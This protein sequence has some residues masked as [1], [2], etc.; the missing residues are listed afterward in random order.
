MLL[1]KS[2]PV[3]MSISLSDC[4]GMPFFVGFFVLLVFFVFLVA[5][6]VCLVFFVLLFTF[7]VHSERIFDLRYWLSI[8]FG[9]FVSNVCFFLGPALEGYGH[10]FG[11]WSPRLSKVM[12]YVGLI[13][14]ALVAIL[15]VITYK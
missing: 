12:F 4:L 11:V 15:C 8:L 14:T 10:F 9:A 2:L 7:R 13:F 6:L 5:L 1:S 3:S